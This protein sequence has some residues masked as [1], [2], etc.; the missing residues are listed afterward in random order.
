[1]PVATVIIKT[2]DRCGQTFDESQSEYG[3]TSLTYTGYRG[4]RGPTG[5]SGGATH[6]GNMLLCLQCTLAFLEFV[7]ERKAVKS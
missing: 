3:Q 4:G 6:R 2:C 1:M 7:R 5:D